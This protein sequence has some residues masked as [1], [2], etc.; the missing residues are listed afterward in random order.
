[1]WAEVHPGILIAL[2]PPGPRQRCLGHWMVC[3]SLPTRVTSA[4]LLASHVAAPLCEWVQAPSY[5]KPPYP[6]GR[7]E[8]MPKMTSWEYYGDEE[9]SP[10][11][12]PHMEHDPGCL[13][14]RANNSSQ[15][16]DISHRE[17]GAS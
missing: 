3:L 15:W 12:S 9:T 11:L 4:L 1:M 2:S 16:K 8:P 5:R 13:K 14:N 7:T 6:I 17:K 10:G